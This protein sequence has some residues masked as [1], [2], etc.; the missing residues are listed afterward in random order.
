MR[1]L[2][3]WHERFAAAMLLRFAVRTK[4]SANDFFHLFARDTEPFDQDRLGTKPRQARDKTEN[5]TE[6]TL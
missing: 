5:T 2:Q 3:D 1:V 4:R 6:G